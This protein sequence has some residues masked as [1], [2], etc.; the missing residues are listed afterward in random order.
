M[1]RKRHEGNIPGEPPRPPKR[2]FTFILGRIFMVIG[3]LTV[4]YLFVTEVLMRVL[5]ALTV[6]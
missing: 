6:K 5:A 4:L 1:F 2:R 3:I